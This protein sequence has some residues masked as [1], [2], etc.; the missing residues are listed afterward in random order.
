[1]SPEASPPAWPLH[2]P[3]ADLHRARNPGL[4]PPSAPAAPTPQAPQCRPLV[5][6]RCREPGGPR[7]QAPASTEGKRWPAQCPHSPCKW[8]WGGALSPCTGPCAR[9]PRTRTSSS[10]SKHPQASL[11]TEGESEAQRHK[12]QPAQGHTAVRSRPDHEPQAAGHRCRGRRGRHGG[13]RC[14]DGG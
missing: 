3:P 14:G 4:L 9:Q 11:F 10:F 2:P 5:G 8:Q 1:M 6:L 13:G 12:V 7:P